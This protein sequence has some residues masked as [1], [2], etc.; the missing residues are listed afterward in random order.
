MQTDT[1][2]WERTDLLLGNRFLVAA[3][4][5]QTLVEC[6]LTQVTGSELIRLLGNRFLVAAEYRQTLV[7]CKLTQV[8]GS[9]LIRC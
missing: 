9:E 7:G 5:R 8:T 3:E 6:K 4:N 2:Y 1:G